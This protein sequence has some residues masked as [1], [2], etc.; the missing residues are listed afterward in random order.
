MSVLASLVLATPWLPQT[1][2]PHPEAQHGSLGG[3]LDD[4]GPTRGLLEASVRAGPIAGAAA[5]WAGARAILRIRSL[6]HVGIGGQTL[7]GGVGPLPMH[8]EPGHEPRA[9]YG[10]V[11]FGINAGT[12]GRFAVDLDVLAGGG[13]ACVTPTERSGVKWRCAAPFGVLEP[14]ITGLFNLRD[15]ARIG[16]SLGYRGVPRRRSPWDLKGLFVGFVVQLGRFDD[17]H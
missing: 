6:Y 12:H 8:A 4:Q 1:H 17:N 5:F 13:V 7:V 16:L 9:A 3:A 15:R 2:G 14:R 10:G 11:T